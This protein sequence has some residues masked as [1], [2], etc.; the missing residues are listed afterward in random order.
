LCLQR[1]MLGLID[2][3]WVERTYPIPPAR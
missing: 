1:E 3:S 2:H